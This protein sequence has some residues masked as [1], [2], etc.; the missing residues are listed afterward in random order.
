MPN[1]PRFGRLAASHWAPCPAQ[2]PAD[3][4]DASRALQRDVRELLDQDRGVIRLYVGPEMPEAEQDQKM[5][6]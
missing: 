5:A 1:S 4:I 2:P 6:S 3:A